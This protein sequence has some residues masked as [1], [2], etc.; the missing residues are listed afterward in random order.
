MEEKRI[1]PLTFL[2][3]RK[4]DGR[5]I[6]YPRNVPLIGAVN[7]YANDGLGISDNLGRDCPSLLPFPIENFK[8]FVCVNEEFLL[9]PADDFFS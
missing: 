4:E 6:P 1:T 8:A 5:N 2:N 7:A 3:P 9:K